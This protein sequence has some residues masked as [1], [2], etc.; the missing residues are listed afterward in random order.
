MPMDRSDVES[1]LKKKGFKQED[2]SHHRYFIYYT[3]DGKKS[4]V[5][6]YTSRGKSYKSLGN[7]LIS[8]M[9]R[10]CKLANADFK[11]LIDCPLDRNSY[12]IKLTENGHI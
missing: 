4:V 9:A 7:N 11:S 10:Q 3:V 2:H 12:E 1:S 6:T 8:Q 5:K